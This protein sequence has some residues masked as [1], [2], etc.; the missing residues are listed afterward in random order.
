[1]LAFFRRNCICANGN[2]WGNDSETTGK[3]I[4][5]VTEAGASK[6]ILKD[7]GGADSMVE[8]WVVVIVAA[9][10]IGSP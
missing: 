1:M 4:T 3:G 9:S 6:G 7:T 10:S 8:D 2:C 5:L